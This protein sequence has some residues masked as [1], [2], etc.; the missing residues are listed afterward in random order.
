MSEQARRTDVL[1]LANLDDI[2]EQG[3]RNGCL[4]TK[5]FAHQQLRSRLKK[6]GNERRQEDIGAALCRLSTTGRI[7]RHRKANGDIYRSGSRGLQ[8]LSPEMRRSIRKEYDSIQEHRS[9]LQ[10]QTPLR[11]VS[12]TQEPERERSFK[13]EVTTASE[14]TSIC[15]PLAGKHRSRPLHL[16]VPFSSNIQPEQEVCC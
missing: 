7:T 1:I 3:Q 4:P 11:S 9:V 10:S 15:S 2:I 14:L 6:A 5:K 12:R 16:S 13:R 8:N